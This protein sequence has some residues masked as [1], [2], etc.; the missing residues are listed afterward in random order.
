MALDPCLL[1]F[2][3]RDDSKMALG[4]YESCSG[5]FGDGSL[6]STSLRVDTCDST[7]CY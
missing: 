1:L 6:K 3:L 5:A 4:I 7:L 2:G